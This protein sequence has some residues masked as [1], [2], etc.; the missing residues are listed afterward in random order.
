MRS[1]VVLYLVVGE[2]GYPSVIRVIRGA[3][4]GLD[5]L[6]VEAVGK[7]RFNPGMKEGKPVAVA[8]TIQVRFDR[9]DNTRLS[10]RAEQTARLNFTLPPDASRPELTEGQIPMNPT[11]SG[12][13]FLRIKMRVTAKGETEDLVTL[14]STDEQW[15]KKVMQELRSWRFRPAMT[16]GQHIPVEGVFELTHG[17]EQPA[18]QVAASSV[19]PD[20]GTGGKPISAEDY[21]RDAAAAVKRSAATAM[22]RRDAQAAADSLDSAIRLKPDFTAAYMMRAAARITLQNYEMAIQDANEVIRLDPSIMRANLVR[23]DAYSHL[24][25]HRKALE[26]Y[27]LYIGRHPDSAPAYN[28]RGVAYRELGEAAKAVQD[29]DRAIELNPAHQKAFENRGTAYLKLSE[30]AK[31]ES[32]FAEV[33]KLEPASASAYAHRAEARA[34]KGDAAGAMADQSRARELGWLAK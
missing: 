30:W 16:N 14:K 4:F 26:D 5:E 29:L 12:D 3:G 18:V 17:R 15:G 31:A 20:S 25:Q 19:N 32:D 33:I 27:N 1:T 2:I 7:W 6:A 28:N 24:G 23:G 13:Q 10:N 22:N 34:G 11:V 9:L 21:Y 8:A